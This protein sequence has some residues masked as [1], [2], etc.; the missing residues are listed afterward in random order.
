MREKYAA[1]VILALGAR[2]GRGRLETLSVMN[3]TKRLFV[4]KVESYD[5]KARDNRL[6]V[7]CQ[8]T[9][10]LAGRNQTNKNIKGEDNMY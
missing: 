2:V 9:S 6:K 5:L 7:F 8:L 3:V 1:L 4:R 10:C